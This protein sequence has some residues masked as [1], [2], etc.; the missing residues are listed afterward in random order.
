[1]QHFTLITK[2]VATTIATSFANTS[3]WD[4]SWMMKLKTLFD[5]SQRKGN[6]YLAKAKRS[7]V[8]F[9]PQTKVWGYNILFALFTF[10]FSLLT[11][12]VF[13]VTPAQNALNV[14][15]N[16]TIQ[17]TFTEAMLTSSFND[18]SSF[19]VYGRTSGRH[20][21]TFAFTGGNTVVTFTP[22]TVFKKGEVV[23]VDLTNK[24][25]TSTN[26]A[27]TPIV[28]EFTIITN[29]SIGRFAT[30]VDYATGNS[31]RSIFV[32]D[33]DGDG[34]GDVV[35]SGGTIS[36]LKNNGDGTFAGKVDYAT[37][38]GSHGIFL[39]DIDGD[40]KA[41]ILA[42][43]STLEVLKNNGD[44]TFAPRV[45]Y[46]VGS[47]PYSLYVA[48]IDGD[49]DN[50]VVVANYNTNY[51]SVL[52]NIGDGTFATKVDYPTGSNVNNVSISI[53]DIDGDG[54][55]DAL[56]GVN[57]IPSG[58]KISVLKN[59]GN[60]TFTTKMD[61]PAPGSVSH[62]VYDIDADGDVDVV[63]TLST[64]KNYGDGTFA[65][66]VNFGSVDP[67]YSSYVSDIDGDGDGDIVTVNANTDNCSVFKNNGDGTFTTKVDYATGSMPYSVFASDID[68][69]GDADMLV[70]NA[71]S[72]TVSV[73]KNIVNDVSVLSN[74]PATGLVS[75]SSTLAVSASVKN[76]SPTA[77]TF[78]TLAQIDTSTGAFSSPLFS[79][80]Q[81]VTS[82][83]S[84]QTQNVS[85]GNWTATKN[86]SYKLRIITQLAEDEDRTN[87]TLVTTFTVLAPT[88][89]LLVV[90]QAESQG[91]A[92]VKN[93][94]T[95]KGYL[96]DQVQV[97]GNI[98]FSLNNWERVVFVVGQ[99]SVLSN[100]NA[101]SLISFLNA[102]KSLL[103][104]GN[105]LASGQ[106]GDAS[107]TSRAKLIRTYLGINWTSNT[108]S[109]VTLNGITGDS[110]GNGVT[111]TYGLGSGN[112]E[113]TTRAGNFNVLD[114]ILVHT[115]GTSPLN[116][117]WKRD[118]GNYNI[119]YAGIPI[120]NTISSAAVE[121]FID[122]AMRWLATSNVVFPKVVSITPAQ[123]ALAVS[124]TTTIQVTF[125]KEINPATFNDTTSFIVSGQTSG[126]HRG[127]F[128]FSSFSS[129]VIPNS[130]F[131]RNEESSQSNG[132]IP[133]SVRN[134]NTESFVNTVVT[135]TPATPLKKGDVITVNV[136]SNVKDANNVSVTPFIS[137]FTVMSELSTGTFATKVDYATGSAPHSVFVTDIDSD[138]DGDI[139][140]TNTG[141]NTVSVLK[142]N[143]DGT[144]QTKADYATG[145]G[146]WSVYASDI[147]DDGDGDIL[148]TSYNA[149]S[150]LKNNGDG[151]FATKVDYATGTTPY[152]VFASDIDGDG[153]ADI[154]AANT[155]SNTVSALK[156]NGDGTFAAKV[157]YTTG[158]AISVFV[159]DIDGDGDGDILVANGGISVL[160]NNG[161][162]IF[163]AKV[164]YATGTYPWSVYASDIDSD[165]DADIM[166][167]NSS[168]N[169]ISVLKNINSVN[170]YTITASS[171]ANGSINP[172]GTVSVDSGASQRFTFSANTGYHVDS[173]IVDG[174]NV[175]SI[176]GYMFYNVT[177][178]HTIRVVF[179]INVPSYIVTAST[180]GQ[181]TISPSGQT[182][183][184][185]GDSIVFTVTPISSCY[186]IAKITL[187]GDSV[188][189]SSPYT[190]RNISATHTVT[191]YFVQKT[192][193]ITESHGANG[194][195]EP[196]GTTSVN[197][198]DSVVYAISPNTG[199]RVASVTK[200]GE[201]PLGAIN[202]YTFRNVDKSHTIFATFISENRP[203]IANA[204]SDSVE[205]NRTTT[206]TLT[207]DDADANDTTL[208]FILDEQP[209]HGN[210]QGDVT[211]VTGKIAQV[212]YRPD[213]DYTGTDS[214]S[215]YV[216]DIQN[217][218]S[219]SAWFII[220]VYEKV[221]SAKYRSFIQSD[222]TVTAA[223]IPK[224]GVRP[225]PNA[226][227]ARD[228]IFARSFPKIKDKS[229]PKYPGGLLLGIKRA[230]SAKAFGWI[231]IVGKGTDMKKFVPH[232]GIAR[233]YDKFNNGKLFYKEMKN[234]KVDK[235]NNHLVGELLMLKMNIAAS[236]DTVT[237][238]GFGNLIYDDPF[239]PNNIFAGKTLYEISSFVDTA[240]TY[241]KR[242]YTTTIPA[243]YASMALTISAINN[244]FNGDIDTIS[245]RPLRLKNVKRID[246]VN[247]LHRSSKGATQ[248]LSD[249][250]TYQP[251]NFMF[252]Q[253]YPNPFNPSTTIRFE[254]GGA[255]LVSLKI[256]NV[257]G[258][259]VTT[260][261]NN[262]AMDEGEHEIQYDASGL[263]SGVYFYRLGVSQDGILRYSE[264]KKLV[265]LR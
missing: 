166:T 87:D 55:G 81:T 19:L 53:S 167:A 158:E 50:D 252:L 108:T 56:V 117:G 226:G 225:M 7:V 232:S 76:F 220:T 244:A 255:G 222:F 109:S 124:P 43:S 155:G 74:T 248:T 64:L 29:V 67:V 97:S 11:A 143:G 14:Q 180:I 121:Q 73:L 209:T 259:E 164:D 191:A 243:M 159:S 256:Y 16:T 264:T 146:P 250:E 176:D 62:H 223:K 154:L 60:G 196:A 160:K 122:Q 69:D 184:Q 139:L 163:A 52:K 104:L 63:T 99:D 129:T 9:V 205:K 31:P 189:D 132:K 240:L 182:S 170:T 245:V 251:D 234:P 157:D 134:D 246:S 37:N 23:T 68:G 173:V 36:V 171:G 187:D 149:V 137:Q 84:N 25:K 131:S 230:D 201:I 47:G 38:G 101:D 192:F 142:N 8:G 111:L 35:V 174:E 258:Q 57:D 219:P 112:K 89:P 80:T 90:Y 238:V 165:G 135:F 91:G 114:S 127:T 204:G 107:T 227:N 183:V 193:T 133:H 212:L 147:D 203:P 150:V 26:T 241:Y 190:L 152:S 21:G 181:G 95:N 123:N 206:L 229:N 207:A 2:N 3:L 213:N 28:F 33:V 65:P 217:A 88:Q 118:N 82:L 22:T 148:T 42:V 210:F 231:R 13:S 5:F 208:T 58:E 120:H 136:S 178:N 125:N 247:F 94:L 199:Y 162:G 221:D 141:S 242:Y 177:A 44:G 75:L 24:I 140:A 32:S 86:G 30:K 262:E 1:M 253:N 119:V 214:F 168:S 61:Y 103:L 102:G 233:G 70:A 130:D 218:R 200:D 257:L 236:E 179:A 83:G 105:Q 51:I 265:L 96:Y 186:K 185:S 202:T 77:K 161:N 115:S 10:N 41:D 260:L 98:N 45:D 34:D 198:G 71:N 20:R 249:F 106:S 110:V 48:D 79:N 17:V 195:I 144:Y 156:N 235:Y 18:T 172:S 254:V 211:N 72:N 12:Q 197:C 153:D 39:I 85:F 194:Q 15:P 78:N 27:I 237:N 49:G 40:A 93:A 224:K 169:T 92:T 216:R 66:K 263:T 128:T 228:T 113:K 46:E 6:V 188:F 126:R 151:T 175:D 215:F 4:N 116:A 239:Q 261:L 100:T 54:D 145:S 138:G 59:N